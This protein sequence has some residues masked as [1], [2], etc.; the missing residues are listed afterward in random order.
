MRIMVTGSSGL[1]GSAIAENLADSGHF[2]L[3]IQRHPRQERRK[4]R[5]NFALDLTDRTALLKA[6]SGF[7]RLDAIVH[8][9]ASLHMDPH[10][11]QM[12]LTNV[13]GLQNILYVREALGVE[14][15]IFLSSVPVVGIPQ[16]WPV[17]ED[18]PVNPQ[19]SYHVTKLAGEWLVK[20]SLTVGID[21]SILRL[22]AP[23]GTGMPK[24]RFPSVVIRQAMTHSDITLAGTGRRRQDYVDVR[25]VASAVSAAIMR[26]TQGTFN[27]G[28]GRSFSNEEFAIKCVQLLNS[29][30]RIRLSGL[31]DSE[32]STDWTISIAQAREVLGYQPE[33]TIEDSILHLASSWAGQT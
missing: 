16:E 25:D 7:G 2:I 5:Q 8:S 33:Y 20:L 32:D 14:N 15:F 31:P 13:V 27:I 28:S 19:T 26:P 9:A 4:N 12:S 10:N 30:S 1:L 6:L 23:L 24:T 21:Y 22:T 17:T 3:G 11:V 18:H 29:R